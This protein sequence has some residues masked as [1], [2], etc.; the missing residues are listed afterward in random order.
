MTPSA[1][2]EIER[3]EA[4]ARGTTREALVAEACERYRRAM[5][6][7]GWRETEREALGE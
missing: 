6:R 7:D 1:I 3:A 4:E 2:R 5:E